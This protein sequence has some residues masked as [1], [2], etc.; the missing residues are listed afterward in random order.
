MVILTEPYR[1]LTE[2]DEEHH[3]RYSPRSSVISA[4]SKNYSLF[5]TH[6]SLR[7]TLGGAAS[8]SWT[9]DSQGNWSSY[10]SNGTTQTETANAQNQITSISGSTTPTYDSNGNMITDQAGN[11]YVYDAWNRIVIAKNSA[12]TVIAQYSYNA[13]GNRITESYPQGGPG[14]PVGI[15]LYLYYDAK[16]QF[17]EMRQNST[18]ASDV[19]R[20]M[21]WSAAYING[22]VLQD[23]TFSN[24]RIYFQQD[25][26]WNTTAIMEYNSSTSTWDI[27]QRY[28]YSPYGNITILNADWSATPTG[29][30]PDVLNLYQG[31]QYD[32]VT[33]LYYDHAR[34][35]S[36]TLGTWTSQD[37][38]GYINGANTYQFVMS[39]PVGNVD[40]TGLCDCNN[41]INAWWSGMGNAI[42]NAVD[43]VDRELVPENMM[44]P[45]EGERAI[46]ERTAKEAAA[47]G[48]AILNYAA[49]HPYPLCAVAP[50]PPPPTW[51]WWL[52]HYIP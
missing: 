38:A 30:I 4:C 40:A 11:T 23:I 16:G 8:Q 20:Q 7:A 33:G 21:V 44:R 12:G 3:H 6:C 45:P 26:N 24:T 39:N 27:V 51:S 15:Q 48:A 29:T 52:A 41:K 28:V 19:I 9:L 1:R 32:R 50:P 46:L 31:M 34:N 47:A 22:V 2:H 42:G 36:T 5:I 17:I 49:N 14:V 43:K 10:T 35:Y 13:F 37:P 18:A 25:A